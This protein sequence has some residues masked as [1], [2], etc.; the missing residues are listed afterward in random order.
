[1]DG[2]TYRTIQ[3]WF[4]GCT[5]SGSLKLQKLP[6]EI[7]RRSIFRN[8]FTYNSF[9]AVLSISS[10]CLIYDTTVLFELYTVRC[11]LG[12]L[13]YDTSVLF[14]LYT[15]NCILGCFEYIQCL[16]DLRYFCTLPSKKPFSGLPCI[17]GQEHNQI[18][19][20]WIF[21]LP[22]PYIGLT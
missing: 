1:M 18:F 15:V 17:H 12:C 9:Y 6:E 22:L 19:T 13:I 10:V 21:Y 20:K 4:Q 2:S 16:F 8:V 11:I 5:G 7:L 3:R 14:E